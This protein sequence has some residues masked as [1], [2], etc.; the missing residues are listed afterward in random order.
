MKLKRQQII[1]GVIILV[2]LILIYYFGFYNKNEIPEN[3]TICPE[4]NPDLDCFRLVYDP[5]CGSDGV[6]YQTACIA[7]NEGNAEWYVIGECE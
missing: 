3:A 6:T 7:C 1:V 4:K 2:I 5:V